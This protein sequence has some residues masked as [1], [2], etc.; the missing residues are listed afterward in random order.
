MAMGQGQGR[1]SFGI[2]LAMDGSK[3][4]VGTGGVFGAG[5]SFV[6]GAGP[7]LL[8]FDEGLNSALVFDFDGFGLA[9]LRESLGSGGGGGVVAVLGGSVVGG[10]G[11]SGGGGG[12]GTAG[13]GGMWIPIFGR[14]GGGGREEWEEVLET[15]GPGSACAMTLN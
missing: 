7:A 4:M 5:G 14:G 1:L 11:V 9:A 13:G 15:S 10:G 8:N 6:V 12:G 3:G 2:G